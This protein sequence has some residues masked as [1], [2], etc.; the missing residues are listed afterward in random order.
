[1]HFPS[2][3][4]H[5]IVVQP[6]VTELVLCSFLPTNPSA[7]LMASPSVHVLHPAYVRLPLGQPP[8]PDHHHLLPTVPAPAS[9]LAHLQ[10]MLPT[11]RR[12][13]HA[14]CHVTPPSSNSNSK[15]SNQKFLSMEDACLFLERDRTLFS[16]C[17][18]CTV[19]ATHFFSL[20]LMFQ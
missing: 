1:M 16:L 20:F 9:V 11:P 7:N 8:T 14:S 3:K 4:N 18:P 13:K 2:Q 17:G 12:V 5:H 19:F 6:T 15:I 10:K